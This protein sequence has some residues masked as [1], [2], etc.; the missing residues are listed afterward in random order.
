MT[1]SRLT[2]LSSLALTVC[3]QAAAA[4][5]IEEI[6]VRG[7]LRP[8]GIDE[9]P[10]SLT[11]IGADV[12]ERRNAQHLENLLGIAPNVNYAA[13]ASRGRYLQIRG[14]GETGQF[15]EPLNASVGI[16]IDHVDFSGIGAVTT[17]YDAEQVEVFRGPQGTLYGANALA[18]LINI[19]TADPG[20][21][22]Q[23][24]I[25]LEAAN[26][27]TYSTGMRASGPLT[28]TL[29]GRLS[30][31]R[32][33]GDGYVDNDYLGRDDTN[34]FDETTVRGKLRYAPNADTTVN[35]MAGRVDID[36]GYDAFSL[37]NSRDTR[38]DEPG[39]DTQDTRFGSAHAVY[40]GFE[41]FAVETTLA[42][43]ESDIAYGYDEDWSYVGFHPFE[44]QSTD[45]YLRDRQTTTAELR[46]VSNPDGRLFGDS[47]EWVTGVYA[48]N[49]DE[50][51]DRHY[52]FRSD[53][54]RSDFDMRRIALFGQTET[55]FGAANTLTVGLRVERHDA[56]YRDVDGAQFDPRDDLWGGRI[57]IDRLIG[58]DTLIYLS[59]ARGYKAG[60]FN[61]DASLPADLRSY[62]PEILYNLE[63]GVKGSWLDDTLT[64]R[65]ALFY[66]WRE[67]MQLAT[68]V[69]RVR[70]DG[71]SQF[72]EFTGNAAEGR[73][74][75]LEGEFEWRLAQVTLFGSL[76]LLDTQ[77]NDFV[78]G[79]GRRLDG[80][81]QTHAPAYQFYTGVEFESERGFFLRAELEGKDAFYFSD[82][83]DDQSS[84]YRLL[85]LSMGFDAKHWAVSLWG[86]NL[87]DA[88][89]EVRGYHFGNDPR[90]DY[91]PRTYTQFGEPRRYGATVHWKL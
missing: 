75:G 65:A 87:S 29:G 1:L 39:R 25:D 2:L 43:A 54:F 10:S 49:Q 55:L 21:A 62:D 77:Y 42:Y 84:D 74:Y 59:L 51:L 81:D 52:T 13:G 91:E 64:T 88:T 12:I 17:L 82:S 35:V 4:T 9:L 31:Q 32:Y 80:R 61:A 73:N 89:Y 34:D 46:L 63:T 57:A 86:R 18:G 41:R 20:D 6:V 26:Y 19:T 78:N 90:I 22:A 14:I 8:A 33:A 72:I 16:I 28:D 37:D 60:G 48:L 56:D 44:Y 5:P 76:G 40:G 23:A 11:V 68:S 53:E 38:S 27:G 66:M 67:D 24:A 85:H 15:I 36:N 3:L 50:R 47:T 7:E 83:H 71:S 79:E 69:V 58:S 45:L 30:I 70:P